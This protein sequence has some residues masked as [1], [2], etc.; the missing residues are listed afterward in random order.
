MSRLTRLL[1]NFGAPTDVNNDMSVGTTP[2]SDPPAN[3]NPLRRA[4]L[5]LF[6]SDCLFAAFGLVVLI[7]FFL[8]PYHA[9]KA[10]AGAFDAAANCVSVNAS[11]KLPGPCS[12]EGANVIQ[13]Y[14]HSSSSRKTRS[15]YYYY[16]RL[17]G[18]YGDPHTVE[19]KNVDT[20]WRT[21]DGDAVTMQRWGDAITA[22]QLPSGESSPTAQNPDWQLRN[23]LS[24]TRTLSILE[25]VL[26]V[27]A[28]L[29]GTALRILP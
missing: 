16:L 23:E 20:W 9:I 11:E 25:M 17:R 28:A 13:R 18:G 10:H 29:S 12:V 8:L 1:G 26:I 14:Y 27:F 6:L 5:F 4:I 15:R 7:A 21:H 2:Q 19:L 3:Q 24:G 22:V